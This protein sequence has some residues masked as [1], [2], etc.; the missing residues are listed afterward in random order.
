MTRSAGRRQAF[1]SIL[2]PI[3]LGISSANPAATLERY[4]STS[5]GH[6]DGLPSTLIYAIT[7]TRNGYLWLGTSDGLVRFDGIDFVPRKIVSST[8][9]P[10]GAVTALCAARSGGL[11]VGSA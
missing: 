6:K 8:D 3:V 11:W 10:L 2:W 5:W 1:R 9:P 4:V 7:Q